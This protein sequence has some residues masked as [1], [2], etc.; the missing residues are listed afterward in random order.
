MQDAGGCEEV[1]FLDRG[2]NSIDPNE[3]LQ[4]SDECIPSAFFPI[5]VPQCPHLKKLLIS[6]E[7]CGSDPIVIRHPQLEILQL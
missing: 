7:P 3:I 5:L 2:Y 1:E 4:I 6:G